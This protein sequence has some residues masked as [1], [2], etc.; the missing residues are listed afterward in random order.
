MGDGD[1]RATVHIPYD[2]AVLG[3]EVDLQTSSGKLRC[4]I[5]AGTQCGSKLR[6][7]GKGRPKMMNPNER[8]DLYVTIQIKV[9]QHVSGEAEQK[10]REYARLSR[11]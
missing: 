1:V 6:F 4:R 7:R 11:T 2:I 5:K 3:G 9:P 10:L 8:G